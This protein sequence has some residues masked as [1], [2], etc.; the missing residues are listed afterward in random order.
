MKRIEGEAAR[1]GLLVEDLLMLARL[2][3]QRPLERKPVELVPLAADAVHDA[4]AAWPDR[5][6]RLRVLPG[7]GVP[8]VLGDD[9]R[10]RQ[11]L[12]N[13]VS[14][15]VTH[16]PAGTVATVTVGVD[17]HD[18][19]LEVAD[20]GPGLD[21]DRAARVFERF[22]RADTART[23]AAGGTGL[24]LSIVAAIVAAHGGTVGVDTS[25]GN[26]SVFRVRIPLAAVSN[27]DEAAPE[28]GA[29]PPDAKHSSAAAVE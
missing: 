12:S 28:G 7:D 25:P 10:L 5:E 17:G 4:T 21:P 23:R 14:N 19:V 3:Q 26:G 11:V 20:T 1:M 6:V 15:A 13:L 24:G 2:D 22:Y 8:V 18:A 16:T 9:A 29:A 27:G